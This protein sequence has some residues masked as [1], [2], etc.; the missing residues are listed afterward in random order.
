MYAGEYM[1]T[2]FVRLVRE[3]IDIGQNPR[4]MWKNDGSQKVL[5]STEIRGFSA[6]FVSASI[7]FPVAS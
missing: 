6:L 2:P 5:V 7:S 4:K 3:V 1:P